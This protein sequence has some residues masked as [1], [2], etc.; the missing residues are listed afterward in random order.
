MFYD[1]SCRRGEFYSVDTNCELHVCNSY[2]GWRPKWTSIISGAFGNHH[3]PGLLFYEKETGAGEFYALDEK[4]G[5]ALVNTYQ[6]WHKD[7]S[8]IVPMFFTRPERKHALMFYDSTARRGEVYP[9]ESGGNILGGPPSEFTTS[10]SFSHVIPSISEDPHKTDAL[11]YSASSGRVEIASLFRP[12]IFNGF[13]SSKD[14]PIGINDIIVFDRKQGE[15]VQFILYFDDKSDDRFQI[16]TNRSKE[17][18]S[19][20]ETQS[21]NLEAYYLEVLGLSGAVTMDTVIEAY[22]EKIKKNHPDKVQHMAKKF[23][24]WPKKET[25]D[26]NAARDFF[27]QRFRTKRS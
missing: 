22:K 3:E 21:F 19:P 24:T 4:A 25:K 11:F 13:H 12:G 23:G 26:L 2:D 10:E 16:Y 18:R 9:L 17:R 27:S 14:W 5:M 1:R 8:H 15:G 7:W 6:G 20:Q